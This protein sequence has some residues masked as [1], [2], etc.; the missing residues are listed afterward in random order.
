MALGMNGFIGIGKETTWGTPV[1]SSDF[2]KFSSE[3]LEHTIE[4]LREDEIRGVRAAPP[5]YEGVWG[6]RGDIVFPVRP[7]T[8]GH[9]LRSALGAPNT[10]GAGSNYTHTFLPS[11]SAFS[12]DCYLPPY[13]IEVYRDMGA[14]AFQYAGCV[15]NELTFEFGISSKIVKC[16]ASIIGKTAAAVAKSGTLSW[17]AYDPF[18][19][20]QIS[21]TLAGSS[22]TTL[23]N[24]T[25]KITNNVEAF[26]ALSGSGV[27]TPARILPAGWF[28]TTV[29][30][31]FNVADFVEYNRFLSTQSTEVALTL[32]ILKDANTELKF[33]FNKVRYTAFPLGISGPGRLTVGISANCKY[34]SALGGEVKAT[35]K[36]NKASY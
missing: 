6:V 23:E 32:D 16:T 3:S 14:Q 11:S 1:S 20:H 10:S 2:L 33:E 12:A 5:D 34:D 27:K 13:T 28:E 8:I 29:N 35:L 31:V 25:V 21:A 4:Q 24:A 17:E 26:A 36:N 18:L 15:V 30:L 7:T 22:I 19:W 9:F